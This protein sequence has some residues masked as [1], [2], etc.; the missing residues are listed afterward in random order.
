MKKIVLLL[1]FILIFSCEYKIKNYLPLGNEF[2]EIWEK[3]GNIEGETNSIKKS[4]LRKGIFYISTDYGIYQIKNNSIHILNE[5]EALKITCSFHYPEKIMFNENG[6]D[7]FIYILN[8][9]ENELRKIKLPF[10]PYDFSFSPSDSLTF[11]FVTENTLL[12]SYNFEEYDT[13]FI[14]PPPY[15][16]FFITKSGKTFIIT[17][18]EVFF[19]PYEGSPFY[20]VFYCDSPLSNVTIDEEENLYLAWR[21]TFLK[22]KD[23]N[24]WEKIIFPFDGNYIRSFTGIKKGIICAIFKEKRVKVYKFEENK[25]IE[26]SYGLEY[27]ESLS[28]IISEAN[29]DEYLLGISR[30]SNGWTLL[31]YFKDTEFPP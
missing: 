25:F 11:Y 29:S 3:V 26:F 8:T 6:V 12:K 30:N 17:D 18:Y 21:K 15:K 28:G 23:F 13:L 14:F 5:N 16:N 10:K 20:R 24:F 1:S 31:F 27:Y 22:T 19:S 9:D 2:E 7:S 4:N